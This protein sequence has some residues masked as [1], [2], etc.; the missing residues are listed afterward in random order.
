MNKI[1]TIKNLTLQVD[2]VD[3][4]R[5]EVVRAIEQINQTLNLYGGDDQ[6]QIMGA[7]NLKEEDIEVSVPEDEEMEKIEEIEKVD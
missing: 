6:P 7:W 5:S 3:G 2:V 1:A 4:N